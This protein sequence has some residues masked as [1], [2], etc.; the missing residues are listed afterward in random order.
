MRLI[1]IALIVFAMSTSIFAATNIN[2]A[3][4]SALLK[5]E[6]IDS[7][8]ADNIIKYRKN[9]KF[10]KIE[11]IKKVDGIGTSTFN[12][13]KNEI[14]VSNTTVGDTLINNKVTNTKD[15]ISDSVIGVKDTAKKSPE[16][17]AKDE[18]KKEVKNKVKETK[19]GKTATKINSSVENV[20]EE[21]LVSPKDRVESIKTK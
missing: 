18:A 20:K 6:G 19:V 17:I 10:E 16:E 3:S 1:K 8:K 2:T 21:V 14:I 5:L 11:D 12:K 13:I 15:S 4:K 9:N 7:K